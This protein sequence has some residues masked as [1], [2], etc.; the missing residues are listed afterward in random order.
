MYDS[1]S[2][3][4][5][6]PLA[7]ADIKEMFTRGGISHWRPT[8][9][10]LYDSALRSASEFN[11]LPEVYFS[12][13]EN[14]SEFLDGINNRIKLFEIPSDL[15]YAYL[16]GH[17]LGR[18]RDWYQILG[19]ALVQNITTDFTQLKV[20]LPKVFPAIQ[21]RKYLEIRFYASQQ[22]RNQEPTDF[23]Y[24]L[25]KLKKKLD[26]GMSKEALVNPIF[27]RLEPLVQ[28][29]VED[30]NPQNTV[31]MLEV[32]AKFEERYSCKIIRVRGIVIM[33]KYEV[34]MSI[35]CPMLIIEEIRKWCVDRVMAKIIIGVTIR[36]AVLEISSS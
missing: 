6:T 26:L 10:N 33:W 16:K 15:S 29:Y 14:V 22:R 5:P 34:G 30:R 18:A 24:D 13:S 27:V 9:F 12:G 31:P 36:M 19:S 2:S 4:N 20:A 32:L 35:G 11:V 1:S 21:I 25:L 23:V 7:H 28:D 17:L 3:V 8:G